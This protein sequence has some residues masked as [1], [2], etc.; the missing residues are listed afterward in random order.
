MASGQAAEGGQGEPA[1]GLAVAEAGQ[2]QPIGP[3]P[4][5]GHWMEVAAQ[6]EEAGPRLGHVA[7]PPRAQLLRRFLGQSFDP[8]ALFVVPADQAQ[9]AAQQ[10]RQ[11]RQLGAKFSG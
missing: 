4:H 5:L 6:V 11:G 1:A 2:A 8:A 3:T 10:L 7:Q 9:R